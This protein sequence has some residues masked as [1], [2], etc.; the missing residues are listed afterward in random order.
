MRTWLGHRWHS[1]PILSRTWRYVRW[2]HVHTDISHD[3]SYARVA[4]DGSCSRIDRL[5][6]HIEKPRRS[7]DKRHKL[8]VQRDENAKSAEPVRGPRVRRMRIEQRQWTISAQPK[9]YLSQV[10]NI[11]NCQN[12]NAYTQWTAVEWCFNIMCINMMITKHKQ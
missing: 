8:Y 2:S 1:L 5:F 4:I 7:N 3:Q 12:D 11:S 6:Q 10:C 9:A